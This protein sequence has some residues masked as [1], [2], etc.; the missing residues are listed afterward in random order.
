MSRFLSS[1]SFRS[2]SGV[3]LSLKIV[4]LTNLWRGMTI[5]FL[6]SCSPWLAFSGHDRVFAGVLVLPGIC[7]IL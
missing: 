2:E 4:R 6:L 3:L 5:I 1:L 7:L